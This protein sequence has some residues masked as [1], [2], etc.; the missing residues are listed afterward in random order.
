MLPRLLLIRV[1]L[2]LALLAGTVPAAAAPTLEDRVYAIASEL[3]CPVCAGQTVAESNA[4]L[5]VQ[6]REEIRARLLRGE[7]REEILAYFV[8]Q[9]GESVLAAPPKRGAGLVLWLTPV[10][11]LL[12]GLVVMVRYLRRITRP[13]ASVSR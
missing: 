11:G 6:M 9:F 7:S 5:A 4:Q 2:I 12:I 10:A 13:P 8:G 3:M 1:F